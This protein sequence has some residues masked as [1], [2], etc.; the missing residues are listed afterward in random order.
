MET[1]EKVKVRGMRKVMCSGSFRTSPATDRNRH[2][3]SHVE[4]LIPQMVV[5]IKD[6]EQYVIQHTQRMFP[7]AKTKNKS[8]EGKSFNGL[9]KIY[10]DSVEDVEG[11]PTCC[12]KALKSL[13]W[14]ELQELACMMNFR[15]IPLLR[16]GSLRAAQEKAYEL[17]QSRIF[18]KRI[19]R[20]QKDINQFK[21]QLRRN[22]E[23]LLL[24]P[25]ESDRRVEE[26]VAKGFSM[27][28]NPG[29]PSESYSFS[30]VDEIIIPSYNSAT[31][32]ETKK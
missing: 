5:D 1:K 19:F 13:E 24:Q 27:I 26:E 29:N 9:I 23:L 17:W 28:V 14:E 2:D 4:V 6:A 32:K 3:F 30:K 8:L 22:Y 7:I 25:D 12:G 15:E 11:E 10:I 31:L 18:K 20:T 16:Q 21:D